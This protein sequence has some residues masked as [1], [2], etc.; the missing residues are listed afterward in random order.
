MTYRL[1][2]LAPGAYDVELDG[3]IVASLV[4]LPSRKAWSI[5]LLEER[6]PHPVP[7]TSAVHKVTSLADAKMWLGNAEVVQTPGG[8]FARQTILSGRNESGVI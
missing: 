1:L 4:A 3:E 2:Q 5:E 7:F 6:L 8:E